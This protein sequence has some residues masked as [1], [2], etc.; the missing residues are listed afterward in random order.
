MRILI[1]T[2]ILIELEDNRIITESFAKFYRLAISNDCEIVY[3]PRAIPADVGRDKD[4]NRRRIITS[5]L[6]KYQS[7][8]DYV[9][10]SSSF[11]SN[12]KNSKINDKIDNK[13]LYQLYRGFVDYFVTQDNGIH[14]NSKK[15]NLS[16]RTL[17]IDQA[18]KLLEK[19]FTFKIPSH[20]ILREH[21]IREIEN[22]FNSS[23]FDSLRKD[24]GEVKFNNWLN[25]CVIENRKC[26]SLI[27]EGNLQAILIYNIEKVEDHKLPDIYKD[28]LKICTLKVDNTAF[29]IKLG[30][31][32]LNKM[33]ELCINQRIK[34]LYL[35]V[36][37]KQ[38]HLIRLLKTFGFYQN[39]FKNSQGLTE[40]Q[41]IKCLDKNKIRISE[42]DISIHPFYFNDASVK[43]YV[44]PIRPEFYSTLFK[45]GKLRQ[46]T[47]FDESPDSINEI[48]GN[49]IIKAYISNSKNKKP[50]K[51]DLIFFYSSRINQVIEPFGILESIEIVSDF[52]ELWGVVRNKTVFTKSELREWLVDKKILHV[53]TFRLIAYL[54][55]NI[56]LQ[57]IKELDS[58]KNK[59]QTITELKETDYIRLYNENY[60]DKRYIIN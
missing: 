18:L 30:E 4:I 38:E 13:Q 48:Q 21:S 49:T 50:K 14:K 44:I 6:N 33:F 37:E 17:T 40:L 46:P 32:F 43:K 47:L 34:Y 39:K 36:Y 5:K 55:N 7:L 2:N 60:F 28:S 52:D 31:L 20:P 25:K 57:K 26:Y 16:D 10:P 24:Y 58:F 41:M 15:I 3:H 22:K 53:I 8:E 29:G 42:N 9:K 12:F 1:D 45:D 56:S 27:V 23:F 59:L 51:G 35:T 11:T 54:K 19:Q